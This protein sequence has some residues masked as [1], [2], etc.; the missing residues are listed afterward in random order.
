[1]AMILIFLVIYLNMDLLRAFIT[2]TDTLLNIY[3]KRATITCS[4]DAIALQLLAFASRN[5]H[6]NYAVIV[7]SV[8]TRVYA[9]S[10]VVA[11]PLASWEYLP[12]LFAS[13]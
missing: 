5:N 10:D 7:L 9:L 11:Q 2:V 1:M 3:E 13:S 4:T 12:L 6:L 8:L